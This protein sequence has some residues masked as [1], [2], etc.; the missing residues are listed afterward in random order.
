MHALDLLADTSSDEI[1]KSTPLFIFLNEVDI[2]KEKL[3]RISLKDYLPEYTG[4]NSEKEALAY[5]KQLAVNR[6]S[7]AQPDKINVYFTTA[8]DSK[9][10]H[11]CLNDLFKKI[12][13]L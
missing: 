12:E 1:F 5:M 9:K 6:C 8:I 3:S 10:M 11:K 13:K 2:F 7:S 4:S